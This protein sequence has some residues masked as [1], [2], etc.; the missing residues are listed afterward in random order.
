S[1]A[2][3]IGEKMSDP[4]QMYLADVFTISANLAAVPSLAFPSGF[5]SGGMPIGMQLTGDHFNEK[6]LFEISWLVQNANGRW[7]NNIAEIGQ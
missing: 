3:N 1:T 4:I 2:F 7:F 6:K 5:S